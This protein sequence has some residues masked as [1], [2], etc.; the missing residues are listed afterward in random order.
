LSNSQNS[1]A[2]SIIVET[3]V[4][5]SSLKSC[6]TVFT[7]AINAMNSLSLSLRQDTV[8]SHVNKLNGSKNSLRKIIKFTEQWGD[9]FKMMSFNLS[10]LCIILF[11]SELLRIDIDKALPVTGGTKICLHVQH[12]KALVN[13]F[14][15]LVKR[16]NTR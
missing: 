9:G 12:H 4:V 10:A 16:N 13:N 3:E 14:E 11:I 15:E 6:L 7:T 5:E 2:A 8:I 1:T